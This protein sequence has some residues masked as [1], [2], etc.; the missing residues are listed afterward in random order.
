V[1]A[2]DWVDAAQAPEAS[3]DLVSMSTEQ[4]SDLAGLLQAVLQTRERPA[5]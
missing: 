5:P 4:L 1:N 3:I 2:L